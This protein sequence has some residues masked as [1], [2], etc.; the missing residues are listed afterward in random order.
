MTNVPR[1]AG[2]IL[3]LIRSTETGRTN[4]DEQYRVIIG[5]KE[6][7]LAKPITAL[8]LD[9]LLAEQRRWVR[10]WKTAS[11]AAG[12]YQIIRATLASLMVE[13]AL[14]GNTKFTP[15]VQDQMAV[16]LLKR[17]GFDGFMAGK[18]S[19]IAF[20][21]NLAKEWASFPVFSAIQGASRRL[22]VGQSY[23]AGDG[24]NKALVSVAA[25][26]GALEAALAEMKAPAPPD[27]A[28]PA[29]KPANWLAAIIAFI[30]NLIKRIR[31]V[32]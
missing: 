22:K 16:T 23:Y 2:P 14:P 8:T 6:N 20:G 29:A 32:D 4:P 28:P 1:G 25:V 11:G 13:L 12:A 21:N 31:H 9:E 19:A 17:R 24:I 3:A 5:H 30:L 15:E 27:P 26:Q 7:K 18:L 10:N